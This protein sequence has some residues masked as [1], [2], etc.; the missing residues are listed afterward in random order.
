MLETALD[1]FEILGKIGEGIYGTVF[2]AQ[3]RKSKQ[4][5]ALKK[6]KMEREEEGVPSTAIR[7]IAILRDLDHE[8]IINLR[9][10]IHWN[11][12]LYLVFELGQCDL[13][14]YIQHQ[15]KLLSPWEVKEIVLQIAKGLLHL[16]EHSILHRDLKPQNIILFP[17]KER[18]LVKI[19]D[20]GLSRYDW[21]PAEKYTD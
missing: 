11:K 2:K 14:Q 5:V 3:D 13:D 19:A 20:F 1:K 9:N 17:E 7:E 12:K 6:V 15:S 4:L 18:L 16:K 8:N 10:I 21:L